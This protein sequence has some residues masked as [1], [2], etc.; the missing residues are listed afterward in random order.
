MNFRT[1]RATTDQKK[2]VSVYEVIDRGLL[3]LD[4]IE[5]GHFYGEIT[6]AKIVTDYGFGLDDDQKMWATGRDWYGNK[7]WLAYPLESDEKI[8]P[9]IHFMLAEEPVVAFITSIFKTLEAIYCCIKDFEGNDALNRAIEYLKV[10]P[11]DRIKPEFLSREMFIGQYEDRR[12]NY[13]C[14]IAQ[15]SLTHNGFPKIPINDIKGILSRK[16]S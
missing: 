2:W 15:A 13:L 4:E 12:R 8:D 14:R 1:L 11:S 5:R 3:S 7:L 16:K 9:K 6:I 10:H